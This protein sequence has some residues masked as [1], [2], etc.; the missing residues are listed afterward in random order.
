[1]KKWT[2]WQDWAALVVGVYAFLSPI[3]TNTDTRATWTMV[4]LGIVTA[5]AALWSLAMPANQVSEYSHA[6]LGILFFISPWVLGFSAIHAMAITAWIV[7]V[8][9][10]IVGVWAVPEAGRLHHGRGAVSAH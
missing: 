3:W 9:T 7:G 2:R 8:V 5:L 6:V 4:V 1:M 10:F